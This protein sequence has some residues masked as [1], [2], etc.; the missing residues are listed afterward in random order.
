M[1]NRGGSLMQLTKAK[2]PSLSSGSSVVSDHFN[3]SNSIAATAKGSVSTFTSYQPPPQ[4]HNL[5]LQPPPSA[6]G[7]YH[8][9]QQ[10]FQQMQYQQQVQQRVQQQVQ[11]HIQQQH[12]LQQQQQ[13]QAGALLD[14]DRQNI[15]AIMKLGGLTIQ[16]A[17]QIYFKK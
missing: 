11:Q 10:Q 7:Q 6:A 1:L 8:N 9:N 14:V 4:I 15:A 13:Q 12:L 2:S 16:E 5:Q 17:T 3:S